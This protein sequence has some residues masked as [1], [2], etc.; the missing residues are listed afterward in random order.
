MLHSE[1][2]PSAIEAN[3]QSRLALRRWGVQTVES[4]DD[5]A[6]QLV[7][8]GLPLC[9][10]FTVRN[11]GK[12]VFLNDSSVNHPNHFIVV[13]TP[14]PATK[15]FRMIDAVNF[16]ANSHGRAVAYITKVFTRSEDALM[17]WL[18]PLT[19]ET[20]DQHGCDYCG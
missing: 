17:M 2:D 14:R 11:H 3:F 13:K 4:A 1:T 9:R 10:G 7:K 5:L 8:G 6:T 15:A 19:L 18:P 12:Y 16:G 20:P